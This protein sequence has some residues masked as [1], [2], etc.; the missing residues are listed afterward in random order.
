MIEIWYAILSFMLTAYVVFDGRNFGA[1]ILHLFV[2]R[3]P[4]ER[5]QVVAAIGPLWGWHEVWLVAAGGVMF[6]AFPRL[7]AVSF[8][9]YYLALFL[10]LWCF[11]LRGIAME[12]GS[13]LN[14]TMWQSFWDFVLAFSSVLLAILFGAA[15]G[16][17]LRGV[18]I[19]ATGVFSMAFFTDFNVYGYVGLLDWYTISVGVTALLLLTAHGAG[20]LALKT[21]GP[22]HD[23]CV[24]ACGWLW[25]IMP[26]LFIIIS[27]ETAFV[28]PDMF[29]GMLQKPLAWLGVLLLLGGAVAVVT[30]LRGKLEERI[31][32]GSSMVIA[33]LLGAGTAGI[34]PTFLYSTLDPN[35]SLTAYN[36]AAAP[37]SLELALIWYPIALIL[38]CTYAR[39][40]AKQYTGRSSAS[41]DIEGG[42]Y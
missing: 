25:C 8:S 1:G 20:Y 33:G 14:D 13:H 36:T 26:A 29:F 41:K 17:V 37:S 3:T 22:V 28:R 39:F 4:Q 10:I 19:D 23:R 38:T 34:F 42:G 31:Y 11:V 40:I 6:V 35:N 30:G 16:N 32:A 5:R 15:L 18:P 9:G 12:V 2:A 27:V 24:K 7:Y 21:D